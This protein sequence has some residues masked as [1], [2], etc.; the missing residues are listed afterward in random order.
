MLINFL[1]IVMLFKYVNKGIFEKKR[2][3]SK[4]VLVAQLSII[5]INFFFK[6]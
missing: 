1:C 4:Y 2:G 5:E 6:V 3:L